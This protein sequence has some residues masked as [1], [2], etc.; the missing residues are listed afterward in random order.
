[1]RK[2]CFGQWHS[3]FLP[4]SFDDGQKPVAAAIEAERSGFVVSVVFDMILGGF[5]RVTRGEL[6]MSVGDKRLMRRVGVIAFLV[7][8]GCLAVMPRRQ[9][10]MV[11]R[12][13]MMLFA[14]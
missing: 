4:G 3:N 12:G 14:R 8:L 6:R 7:V 9:F 1:L 13:K 11:G 10:V 5:I 2:P